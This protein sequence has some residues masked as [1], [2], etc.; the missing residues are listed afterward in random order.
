VSAAFATIAALTV[1]TALTRASGV[2]IMHGRKLPTRL[3]GVVEL[4]A[5]ALL[6]AL[7]VV[8]LAG[9]GRAIEINESLAG[10]VAAGGVLWWRRSAL[11]PAIAAAAA[12]TALLRAL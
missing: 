11:L 10:V 3:E 4:L 7:I 1:T 9:E 5:P 12:V 8:E 2:L 6:T